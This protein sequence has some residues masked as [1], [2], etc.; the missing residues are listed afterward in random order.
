MSFHVDPEVVRAAVVM[1]D[2]ELDAPDN[3][4]LQAKVNANF[5]AV[6]DIWVASG[7]V[8]PYDALSEDYVC[9]ED[10]LCVPVGAKV[11]PDRGGDI[12]SACCHTI[13]QAIKRVYGADPC[14]SG[15]DFTF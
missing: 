11:T 15:H 10:G 2:L 7:T 1:D 5:L 13:R 6:F 4:D 9:D 12:R 8:D 3:P 14:S